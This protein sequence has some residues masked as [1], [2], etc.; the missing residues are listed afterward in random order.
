MAAINIVVQ[1]GSSIT[2]EVV[3]VIDLPINVSRNGANV[4]KRPRINFIEGS[5]VTLNVADNAAQN[6]VDVTVNS[7]GGGGG[8][9]VSSVFGRTGAVVAA[10]NDYDADKI[11]ETSNRVF[12][13]PAEKT[14]ITHSNRSIL[15]AITEAFT[16]AL[17]GVYDSCVAWI[18]A[19]GTNLVNHL[20]DTTNPHN[21]T[22]AQV[23]LSN[24]DNTSDADKPIS[25]AVA[26][27]LV[28][29][30]DA[31][32]DLTSIAGLTPSN[33]DIIQR[34]AGTWTNR[35]P[36]QLL[37]DLGIFANISKYLT[38]SVQTPAA[39]AALTDVAG[40]SQALAAN[41]VWS[42]EFELSCNT[43]A[44]ASGA[45]FAINAPTGATIQYRIVANNNSKTTFTSDAQTAINTSNAP[46][47]F[48]VASVNGLYVRI[49]GQVING[50]NAGTLQLRFNA[51]NTAAQITAANGTAVFR[52]IL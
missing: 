4:G 34:K 19:N 49:S 35:T 22:K 30:Q 10:A 27:A 51:Q 39:S 48:A 41:E 15:D 5:N 13:S 12:V 38:A 29:K 16:T 21:V 8:G 33:D 2:A 50:A 6:R 7:T 52:R 31:D 26:T 24:V 46:T 28:S 44:S 17:K 32:S 14:A 23:G 42:Y 18:T 45:R 43:N 1:L 40:M 25:T 20:T 11:S 47:C 9:G 37:T 36:A 3:P